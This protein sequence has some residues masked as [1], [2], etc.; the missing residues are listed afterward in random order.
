MDTPWRTTWLEWMSVMEVLEEGCIQDPGVGD[1][2]TVFQIIAFPVDQIVHTSASVSGI[3]YY[4]DR[5]NRVSDQQYEEEVEEWVGTTRSGLH[6]PE[7]WYME[8]RLDLESKWKAELDSNRVHN[9][10]HLKRSD[11][12]CS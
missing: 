10:F 1:P 9:R 4:F 7:Q 8:D 6:G 11:E 5:A 12:S 3:Q 2:L